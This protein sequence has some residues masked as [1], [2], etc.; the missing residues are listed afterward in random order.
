MDSKC[1]GEHRKNLGKH[2]RSWNIPAASSC[3]LPWGLAGIAEGDLIEHWTVIAWRSIG[4]LGQEDPGRILVEP[5][6]RSLG[7]HWGSRTAPAAPY[8]HLPREL[9]NSSEVDRFKCWTRKDGGTYLSAGQE[10][11]WGP[12]RV[13]DRKCRLTDLSAGLG[14]SGGPILVSDRKYLGDRFECP[15]GNAWKTT[16]SARQEECLEPLV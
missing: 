4:R 11:L 8:C 1:L 14:V 13:L 9:A 6:R 16:V 15:S 3:H 12:I 5:D 2:W 10:V 7:E